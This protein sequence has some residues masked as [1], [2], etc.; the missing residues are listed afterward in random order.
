MEVQES[1]SVEVKN[2]KA[3]LL[4]AL[5]NMTPSELVEM[6][7]FYIESTDVIMEGI[8]MAKDLNLGEAAVASALLRTRDGLEKVA[9]WIGMHFN[10]EKESETESKIVSE[11]DD[12]L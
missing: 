9:D 4:E 8:G 5:K 2:E 3:A 7:D 6:I 1:N 11:D 10:L 12:V